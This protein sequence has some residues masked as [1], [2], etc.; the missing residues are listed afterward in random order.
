MDQDPPENV[1]SLT[2]YRRRRRADDVTKR[3]VK[4]FAK[5][6]RRHMEKRARME[7]RQIETVSPDDD[8]DAA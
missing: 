3:L 2:D 7:F 8:G 5:A 4:R 6:R 1:V